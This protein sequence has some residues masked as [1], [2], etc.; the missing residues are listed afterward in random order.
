MSKKNSLSLYLFL[1]LL[2]CTYLNNAWDFVLPALPL[3]VCLFKMKSLHLFPNCK[4][5]WIK[6]SAKC[7]VNLTWQMRYNLGIAIIKSDLLNI[8]SNVPFLSF[9]SM[10]SID[11]YLKTTIF[12][13]QIGSAHKQ[14]ICLV[15]VCKHRICLYDRLTQ[16]SWYHNEKKSPMQTIRFFIKTFLS[17]LALSC[18]TM[19]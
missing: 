12:W 9:Y 7:N 11:C 13:H 1:L 14:N 10:A 4:S 15:T 5:L 6:A 2:A 3:S 17:S 16:L 18:I 19:S 8:N